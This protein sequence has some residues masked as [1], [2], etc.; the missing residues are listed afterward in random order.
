[1]DDLSVQKQRMVAEARAIAEH[2]PKVRYEGPDDIVFAPTPPQ[3][4]PGV[5][6]FSPRA[7]AEM[8]AWLAEINRAKQST[9]ARLVA[10]IDA[11]RDASDLA[12]IDVHAGSI[13]GIGRWP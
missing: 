2:G 10:A 3:S 8:E 7:Y 1:M 13:D 11:A 9:L 4:S 5:F 12:K 6:D